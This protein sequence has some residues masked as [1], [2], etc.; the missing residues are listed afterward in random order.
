ME[1]WQSF[2]LVSPWIISYK[3]R[4]KCSWTTSVI[5]RVS[6]LRGWSAARNQTLLLQEG[7]VEGGP[8]YELVTEFATNSASLARAANSLRTKIATLLATAVLPQSI[9]MQP[10]PAQ[11]DSAIDGS[12]PPRGRRSRPPEEAKRRT[13]HSNTGSKT[14]RKG[15][16]PRP[17]HRGRSPQHS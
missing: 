16:G 4:P 3:P 17:R 8:A 15:A 7:E 1:T 13:S 6:S 11:P 14:Q 12:A 9:T 10:T 2:S 5:T